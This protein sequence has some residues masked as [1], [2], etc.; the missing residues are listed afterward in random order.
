[1][2]IE[3]MVEINPNPPDKDDDRR[4]YSEKGAHGKRHD[5]QE[6]IKKDEKKCNRDCANCAIAKSCSR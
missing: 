4:H 2:N 5:Y 3:Y 6:E 1:M